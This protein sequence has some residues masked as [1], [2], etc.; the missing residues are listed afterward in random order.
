MVCRNLVLQDAIK[1]NGS[2]ILD[3]VCKKMEACY[4]QVAK[5]KHE[6]H[7]M[8]VLLDT[9]KMEEIVLRLLDL[10]CMLE[11]AQDQ[12]GNFVVQ[13]LLMMIH[14][15]PFFLL[16]IH[17]IFYII[18]IYPFKRM[19]VHTTYRMNCILFCRRIMILGREYVEHLIHSRTQPHST[20]MEETSKTS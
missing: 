16:H 17:A 4:D 10:D 14:V 7:V 2:T 20:C 5:E 12:Y 6:S 15:S 18:K 8:V 9:P 11:L 1:K 3:V 19:Y 13:G